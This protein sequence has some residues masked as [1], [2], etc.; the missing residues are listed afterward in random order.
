MGAHCLQSCPRD[1]HWASTGS[2]NSG[3]P[4]QTVISWHSSA[5]LPRTTMV[6]TIFAN[7]SC[8]DHER[9]TSFVLPMSSHCCLRISKTM[10]SGADQRCL[11]L[12][13]CSS[14]WQRHLHPGG[15][16][17]ETLERAS[18]QTIRPGKVSKPG[19]IFRRACGQ[20]LCI[21]A[22]KWRRRPSAPLLRPHIGHFNSALVWTV[23]IQPQSKHRSGRREQ[24]VR[25]E[26]RDCPIG[27]CKAVPNCALSFLLQPT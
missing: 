14:T 12:G 7:T 17:M 25:R 20:P 24:A 26:I 3:N 27:A 13:V 4:T 8:S 9:T 21:H 19:I 22:G 23:G 16:C 2:G 1:G 5:P 10:V 15:Q 18:P 11:L 6:E